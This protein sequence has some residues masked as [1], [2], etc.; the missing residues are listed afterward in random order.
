MAI[1]S[2]PIKNKNDS[3]TYDELRPFNTM[4]EVFFDI[5]NGVKLKDVMSQLIDYKVVATLDDMYTLTTD[6][7]SVGTIVKIKDGTSYKV[8]DINNLSN[9]S[10]YE[11]V[12]NLG[13]ANSSVK[14]TVYQSSD[15]IE[16]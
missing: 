1:L 3:G 11:E 14:L 4:E 6:D 15:I 16:T 5:N 2:G 10:G 7:V 13:A 8:V 9:S 12:T